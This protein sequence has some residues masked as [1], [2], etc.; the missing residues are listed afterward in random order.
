LD[1]TAPIDFNVSY[2]QGLDVIAATPYFQAVGLQQT[3]FGGVIAGRD[4]GYVEIITHPLWDCNVNNFGPVLASAHAQAMAAGATEVAFKSV[5][6]LLR[7]P[8]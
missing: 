8:Y 1:D 6:E 7:R 5:F 3:Q 2:W 4:D